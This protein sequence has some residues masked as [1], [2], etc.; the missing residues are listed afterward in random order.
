M[1]ISRPTAALFD[2]L[3]TDNESEKLKLDDEGDMLVTAVELV[4]VKVSHCDMLGDF[5]AVGNDDP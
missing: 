1:Q 4:V 2:L 3:P 5:S